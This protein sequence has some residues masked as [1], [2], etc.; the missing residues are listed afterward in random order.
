MILQKLGWK[1][2]NSGLFFKTTI[3][4]FRSKP[5]IIPATQKNNQKERYY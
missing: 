4:K 5:L 1:F 2:Q 3:G